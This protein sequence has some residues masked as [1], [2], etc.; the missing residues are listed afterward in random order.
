ME[1]DEK[2]IHVL[3]LKNDDLKNIDEVLRNINSFL[4]SIS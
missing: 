2:G 1:M 4:D 3:R